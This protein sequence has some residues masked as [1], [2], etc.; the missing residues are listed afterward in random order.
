MRNI[1][2]NIKRIIVIGLLVATTACSGTNNDDRF[3]QAGQAQYEYN[4]D[5]FYGVGD[6]Y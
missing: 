3:Q 1:K 4:N 2:Q 6:R 5:A